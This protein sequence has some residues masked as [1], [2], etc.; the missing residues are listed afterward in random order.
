MHGLQYSEG[1]EVA[2]NAHNQ[3]AQYAVQYEDEQKVMNFSEQDEGIL[4]IIWCNKNNN[5]TSAGEP[6]FVPWS[7]HITKWTNCESTQE[8]YV[9]DTYPR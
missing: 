8:T 6:V 1:Q 5:M 9:H 3:V 7:E 2:I 4:A